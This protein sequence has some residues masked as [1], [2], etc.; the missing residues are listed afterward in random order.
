MPFLS[1]LNDLCCFQTYLRVAERGEYV[2]H[3]NEMDADGGNR[4]QNATEIHERINVV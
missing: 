3:A 4:V 1:S 2:E